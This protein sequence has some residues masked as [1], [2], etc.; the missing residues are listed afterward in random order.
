MPEPVGAAISVDRRWRINGHARAWAAVTAGKVW[1][2]QA[3]T[4]GWKP[5]RALSAGMGR[6]ME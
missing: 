4:A 2:N 3:L 6:F 1:L 5:S